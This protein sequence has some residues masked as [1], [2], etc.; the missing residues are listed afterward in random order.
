MGGSGWKATKLKLI[1]FIINKA[2]E[3]Q[4]EGLKELLLNNDINYG[5]ESILGGK[6]FDNYIMT[7][8]RDIY[9]EDINHALSNLESND[10]EGTKKILNWL[11]RR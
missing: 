4:I 7:Q 8:A 5:L 3:E 11:L 1:K 9:F 10:I 2:S 6:E